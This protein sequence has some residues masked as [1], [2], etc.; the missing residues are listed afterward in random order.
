MEFVSR[1]VIVVSKLLVY[2]KKYNAAEMLLCVVTLKKYNAA[3]MLLCV[4]T[5]KK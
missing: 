3:E 4:V 2:C 1:F 5:L